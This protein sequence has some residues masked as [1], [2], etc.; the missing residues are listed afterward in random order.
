MITFSQFTTKWN[1]YGIDFDGAY[2]D[3]CMD[4]M[5]QY[6]VEVLGLTD[7]RI[8]SAPVARTVFEDFPNRIGSQ[9]FD[10]I[11]NS[12]TGVPADGDIIFWKEPYG[13]YYNSITKTYQYAGHV[14]ISK[15]SNVNNVVA[16]EQNNPTGTKCHIQTHTDLYKGVMGWLHPKSSSVNWD[17]KVNKMKNA[18]NASGTSESK[19]KE[20]DRIFH[21]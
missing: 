20:A 7:G 5:H 14:G 15:G 3:Q 1:G 17:D 4:L 2:G 16:F 10:R 9:Y 6:I 13:Y 21:S 11:Y 8:L 18:L 12:A 19:A